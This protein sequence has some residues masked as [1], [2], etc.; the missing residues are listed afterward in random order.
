ML[1]EKNLLKIDGSKNFQ[2]PRSFIPVQISSLRRNRFS[3]LNKEGRIE[4]KQNF[5]W[6]LLVKNLFDNPS[7]I[8]DVKCSRL[9]LNAIFTAMPVQLILFIN[10]LIL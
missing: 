4:R 7:F 6:Q 1:R 9:R 8:K 2:K 3:E 10:C 5:I